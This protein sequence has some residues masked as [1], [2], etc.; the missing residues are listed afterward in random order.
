M[1]TNTAVNLARPYVWDSG[2]E[3]RRES[4]FQL[5]RHLL[6]FP[7]EVSTF[8]QRDALSHALWKYTEAD[9]VAPHPKYHIRF[10]SLGAL[11]LG[12]PAKVNHEH[13][14]PRR[15]IIDRL[16]ARTSWSDADLRSFLAEHAV[17]CIVTV[18]EHARLGAVTGTGWERYVRAGVEVWDA[19]E[20]VPFALPG[21]AEDASGLVVERPGDVGVE[22][23]V[24]T[25]LPSP[26]EALALKAGARAPLLQRLLD[27]FPT[28]EAVVIVGA[29]RD[30]ARPIGD[31]LRVHD[32]AVEEPSPAVGYLHWNGKLSARLVTDDLP[33]SLREHSA[34][35]FAHHNRYGVEMLVDGEESLDLAEALLLLALEKVREP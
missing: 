16:K 4:A 29:T 20:D 14:W 25:P 13:V 15:W 21:M 18:E 24:T 7:S 31:Y 22:P 12:R 27:R 5:I 26:E 1:P 33:V 28:D 19:H 32:N 8:H 17:A 3:G 30:P 2:L 10:R 35:R 34:L 6:T 9:G 23:V 11:D